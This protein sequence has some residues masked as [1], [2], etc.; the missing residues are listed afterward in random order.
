MPCA[1][2]LPI[3]PLLL[4]LTGERLRQHQT[5]ATL[6]NTFDSGVAAY[7]AGDYAKAYKIWSSDRR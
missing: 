7:D 5:G 3:L 1:N 6:K 4:G 2:C